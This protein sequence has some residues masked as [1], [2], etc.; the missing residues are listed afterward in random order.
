MPNQ[1]KPEE[2]ILTA[3]RL[4]FPQL[5]VA[6]SINGGEPMFGATFL[7]EKEGDKEQVMACHQ[8]M[9]HVARGKWGANIPKL[10]PDKLALRDGSSKPDIDG[11]GD[12]VMFVSA[13]SRKP[14]PVVDKNPSV[15]LTRDTGAKVYAGCYVNAKIRFWAQDNQFGKRIN[16]QLVAVQFVADGEAFGEAPV[17]ADEVFD[18]IDEGGESNPFSEQPSEAGDE[19]GNLLG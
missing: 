17:K 11:Y 16:A 1:N 13:N 10:T 8:A 15:V 6:K 18:N 12:T 5:F 3:V 4:S 9:T 14:F 2:V 7:I 19:S